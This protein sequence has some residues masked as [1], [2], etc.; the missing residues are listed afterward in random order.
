MLALSNMLKNSNKS[1]FKEMH[2]EMTKDTLNAFG[3]LKFA[4]ILALM[5]AH[6]HSEKK[7]HIK[8]NASGFAILAIILQLDKKINIWHFIIF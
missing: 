1:K 5:L 6:F 3:I 8:I 7:I 4:F 2:F